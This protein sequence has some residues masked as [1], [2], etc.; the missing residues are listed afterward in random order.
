MYLLKTQGIGN[1]PDFV[2][3]RDK[4]FVLIEHF[5]LKTM[6]NALQK[7]ALPFCSEILKN[8]IEKTEYGILQKIEY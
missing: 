8:Y 5:S 2:Q 4:N 7:I 3:I 1:V 6:K